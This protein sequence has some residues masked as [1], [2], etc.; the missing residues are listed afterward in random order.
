MREDPMPWRSV[1]L[2]GDYGRPA[3]TTWRGLDWAGYE[4]DLAVAGSR[5][6]YLDYTAGHHR[7][8]DTFVLAHG[9]GG[10]WQH[11][12]ETIPA[13]GQRGRVIAVDLPGFGRSRPLPG[14]CSIDRFADAIA[15]LCRQLRLPP[16]VFL[17]HSLGGPLAV[18]FATRHPGLA[19]AIV[20]VAGTVDVF[21]ETLGGRRL[22]RNLRRHP[23]TV[24]S[25]YFE[26]LTAALPA[27]GALRRQVSRRSGLRRLLLWPYLHQPA[28]LPADSV[29]VLLDGAGA[30]GVLPTALAVG[31]LRP[32]EGLGRIRCPVMAIGA[33]HDAISPLPDLAA[34]AR[35]V[36]AARTVVLEGTGH[37]LML[38]R[39]DAF[40]TE[41]TSFLDRLPREG[42]TPPA[43]PAPSPGMTQ[44]PQ[45]RPG[46]RRHMPGIHSTP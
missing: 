16:A 14:R 40:N 9:L 12:S 5:L 38:E 44:P 35:A 10:R 21:A 20:L 15:E 17:G 46:P 6:H 43:D 26:V 1:P 18:R 8:G 11:W 31:R 23:K 25:T 30:R 34:F 29:A 2:A 3:R 13:L 7:G 22:G 28:A 4:H 45:D 36:P 33:D 39:P 42:K 24:A 37:M 27:P 41:V 32:G 19:R